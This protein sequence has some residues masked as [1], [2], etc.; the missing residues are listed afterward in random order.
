MFFNQFPYMDA[1]ELNLDW[2]I[3]EVKRLKGEMVG[4]E[5]ANEVNYAGVWNITQ[6]YT[7]WSVVL[8]ENTGY[9][10]IALQPVPTG[11]AITNSD[12]WLL[13]AP[14]KI[15]TAFSESSYNAIANK[16]VT[17][18]FNE[19][20]A[21]IANLQ[22]TTSEHSSNIEDLEKA[23][24]TITASINTINSNLTAEATARESADNTLDARIDNIIALPDGSTT[25]DAELI[26]IRVGA[27]DRNY[28]SAGD[29][30]R[31]QAK[32]LSDSIEYLS[33]YDA[34]TNKLQS[35]F[36]NNRWN[37]TYGYVSNNTAMSIVF[38]QYFPF[39]VIIRN[40]HYPDFYGC[41]VRTFSTGVVSPTYLA[42]TTTYV[43]YGD[44]AVSEIVLPKNT[45]WTIQ[46]TK[47]GNVN[48]DLDTYKVIPQF[49]AGDNIKMTD[50]FKVNNTLVVGKKF[51]PY[52]KIQDAVDAAESGDTILILPGTYEEAV[53]AWGK[54]VH[55]LGLDRDSTIILDKSGLYSTPTLEINVGS[56]RNITLIETGGTASWGDDAGKG[57]AYTIH[58]ENGEGYEDIGELWIENCKLINKKHAAVGCG[59][60]QD[61]HV[62]FNNCYMYSGRANDV[63]DERYRG[64]FYYHTNINENISGQQ[65]TVKDCEII[66]EDTKCFYGGVA[67]PGANT[68]TVRSTFINN[69]FYAYAATHQNS[70]ELCVVY[71]ILN[72]HDCKLTENSQGNNIPALNG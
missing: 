47:A 28:A 30:V 55:L 24:E 12:Y 7:A 48:I 18:K 6:Q 43:F 61:L 23:D 66:N 70:N 10:M 13:V 57:Y 8:N 27:F 59:L 69:N 20:D 52:T 21:N 54:E 45:F 41:Q 38:A 2:I 65:M 63:T 51:A 72:Y 64:T 35:L 29:S 40:I 67:T 11:I 25:A 46:F 32:Y 49:V 58:I 34:L 50:Q 53:S 17:D 22:E 19:V 16:R 39:D 71:N 31:N 60:Y 37:D 36:V 62:H 3:S 33:D 5:A 15:D 56:V 14:F 9:M 42:T 1:H 26:D 44:D 68:G 4:F